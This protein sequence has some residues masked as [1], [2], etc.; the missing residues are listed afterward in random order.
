MSYNKRKN[1]NKIPDGPIPAHRLKATS[2]VMAIVFVLLASRIG[3]IQFVQGAELKEK[4]SRQQTLNKIISPQRG[5]ICDVNGKYLAVSAQVDTITINP[6]SFIVKNNDPS[7]AKKKTLDNQQKIAKAL[8]DIFTLNYEET[9]AKVQS[10]KKTE[11]IAKQ[12]D[13][14]LV[15]KLKSWQEENEITTGINIDPDTK[16][17]Y[18]YNNLASHVLG[19]T[20]TDAQ[21]LYGIESSWDDTLKGTSRKNCYNSKCKWKSNI[22]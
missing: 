11:V 4:A 8:S 18:P 6:S 19:F 9:L 5:S 22:R 2:K 7:E 14:E 15:D 17:Y 1:K 3:W 21:G 10:E 16:R 20:G 12:V 13:K